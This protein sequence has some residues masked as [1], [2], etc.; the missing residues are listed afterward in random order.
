ML[1]KGEEST[2]LQKECQLMHIEGI[3]EL[4][5][6]PFCN[7]QRNYTKESSM[8]DKITTGRVAGKTRI[9]TWWHSIVPQVTYLL[10]V[11]NAPLW[12]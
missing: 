3:I 10:K 11:K 7:L 8:N 6:T 2:S 5:K 4:E 9:F 1:R 12:W